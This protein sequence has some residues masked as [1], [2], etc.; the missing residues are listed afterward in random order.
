MRCHACDASF[1]IWGR[2]RAHLEACRR[3]VW[4]RWAAHAAAKDAGKERKAGRLA[5]ELL[6]IERDTPPMPEALKEHL[7]DPNVVKMARD[8]RRAKLE[9]L[10]AMRHALTI[11]GSRRRRIFA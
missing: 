3:G 1:T 2:Y 7:R 4:A 8:K 11:A 6:G 9:G 5:R 10:R